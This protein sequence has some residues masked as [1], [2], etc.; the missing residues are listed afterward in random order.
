MDRVEMVVRDISPSRMD[1]FYDILLVEKEGSRALNIPIGEHEANNM[2]L[3]MDDILTPRPM[4]YD[5]FQSIL[6]SFNIELV[7]IVINRFLDGNYFALA[8]FSDQNK[9]TKTIDIRPS[10]AI[11]MAF[12]ANAPIFASEQVL[13]DVS[14]NSD[15]YFNEQIS[16]E[17]TPCS[18]ADIL[19]N[20]N[21]EAFG[22]NMLKDLLKDAIAKEDYDTASILRDRIKEI[23]STQGF[24]C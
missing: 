12:R 13:K 24:E 1:L 9:Q 20:N 4:T 14:F 5:T 8:I 17:D 23:S 19:S 18:S 2:A 22:I 21:I 6:E 11:N 15:D 16:Q 10:D 7:E 3:F